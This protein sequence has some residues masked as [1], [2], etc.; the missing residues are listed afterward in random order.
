VQ[1]FSEYLEKNAELKIS[2]GACAE[3]IA[4]VK[5]DFMKVAYLKYLAVFKGSR[6]NVIKLAINRLID[7]IEND[8]LKL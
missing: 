6:S 5:M 3:D 8:R 4:S 7:D 2:R 1:K